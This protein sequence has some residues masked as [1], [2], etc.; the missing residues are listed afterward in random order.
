M[1]GAHLA[2][3]PRWAGI[4]Q[5]TVLKGG[6]QGSD[7]AQALLYAHAEGQRLSPSSSWEVWSQENLWGSVSKQE[8]QPLALTLMPCKISSF[9]S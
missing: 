1:E 3:E 7:H 5:S 2:E 8:N 4:K 9:F 6:L